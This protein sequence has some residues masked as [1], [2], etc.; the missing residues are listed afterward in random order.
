MKKYG[1]FTLVALSTIIMYALSSANA[2]PNEL[3]IYEVNKNVADFGDNDFS[4]PE[5][6]KLHKKPDMQII[7]DSEANSG[8]LDYK[9]ATVT[10]G[11]GFNS[12]MVW[13]QNTT[14]ESI[15]KK[16]GQPEEQS[17]QRL[18]YDNRYGLR[19]WLG[20]YEMETGRWAYGLAE[21]KIL[22][23]FKG[24]LSSGITTSSSKQDV[25]NA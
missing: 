6:I 10:E 8:R 2:E 22:P 9:Y 11:F 18:N 1:L 12:I 16:L 19:F 14:R 24:K 4:T 3:M 5:A 7:T 15:I 23:N 25:F 17:E 13:D 20:S 21:I